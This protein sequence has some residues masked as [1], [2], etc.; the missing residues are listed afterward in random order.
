M[1]TF[2]PYPDFHKSLRSLDATR[3][4]NQVYNEGIVLLSGFWPRH[5]ASLM[6]RGYRRAF[7]EYLIAGLEVLEERGRPAWHHMT[8]L[9]AHW[10]KGHP[11]MPQ[12]LGQRAFHRSHKSNLI[13]K[14][15][16]HYGRLWP[17]VPSN[18]P[19]IWPRSDRAHMTE[20]H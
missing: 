19:Y 9:K 8:L 17:K 18:L 2:L 3:L 15:P 12:W 4:G 11:G 14:D 16:R 20:L 7:A 6:W 5:P 1:Q 10:D 13:R